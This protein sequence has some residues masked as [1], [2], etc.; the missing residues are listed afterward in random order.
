MSGCWTNQFLPHSSS[1]LWAR[2][3]VQE[4]SEKDR[5]ICTAQEESANLQVRTDAFDKQVA[6]GIAGIVQGGDQDGAITIARLIEACIPPPR[7]VH[8]VDRKEWLRMVLAGVD[9]SM[10]AIFDA[11]EQERHA[12]LRLWN[13]AR[14][15]RDDAGVVPLTAIWVELDRCLSRKATGPS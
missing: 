10:P 6:H 4:L 13:L 5:E 14:L 7:G 1:Q 12:S 3:C 11:P 15:Q 8:H 2:E 9:V